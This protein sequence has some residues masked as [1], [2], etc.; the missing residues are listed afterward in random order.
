MIQGKTIIGETGNCFGYQGSNIVHM[1]RT[2][3]LESFVA[4]NII[5]T[6]AYGLPPEDIMAFATSVLE[7]FPL[8]LPHQNWFV[9]IN[10][11]A[12]GP[13]ATSLICYYGQT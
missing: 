3:L 8:I 4:A 9:L 10:K 6:S 7:L 11:N 5:T 12:R 13:V 1:A 2:K